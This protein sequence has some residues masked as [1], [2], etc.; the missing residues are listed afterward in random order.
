MDIGAPAVVVGDDLHQL[1]QR[2]GGHTVQLAHGLAQIVG[3]GGLEHQFLSSASC[4]WDGWD[5]ANF[6]LVNGGERVY[7]AKLKDAHVG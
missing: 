6:P 2:H 3:G 5:G 7:A 4:G 1:G